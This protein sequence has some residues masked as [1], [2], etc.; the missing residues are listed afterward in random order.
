MVAVVKAEGE[1][2]CT[3]CEGTGQA[4]PDC[5]ACDGHG[6]VDDEDEGGTMTCPE[7]LD[8]KCESCKGSGEKPVA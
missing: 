5:E 2:A 7:C 4:V 1:W 8:D 3:A 6:W